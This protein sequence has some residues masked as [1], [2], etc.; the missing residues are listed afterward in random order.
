MK[1]NIKKWLSLCTFLCLFSLV[2][3]MEQVHA[4]P[5]GGYK[6]VN[7]R[8]K[9]TSGENTYYVE[10]ATGNQGYTN[11]YYGADAIYLGMDGN[12]VKFKLSGVIGYVNKSEVEL[13]S[14]DSQVD[15]DKYYTSFYKVKD[16]VIH[17]KI[18]TNIYSINGY[19]TIPIGTNT[20]GLASGKDY[21]SY[22]GHY[23]YSASLEGYKQ[24]TED[25]ISGDYSHAVNAGKPYYN[26]YQY[27]SH[28]TKTNYTAKDIENFIV[29]NLG[30]TKKPSSTTSAGKNESLLYGEQNSFINAQNSFGANALMMFGVAM[31]ESSSGQASIPLRTNN[32]FGHQAYDSA[33]GASANGYATVA[34]GILAHAE[35]FVSIDYMDPKDY[36]NRYQGGHLGNKAS[37]F[38]VKYASDPY[39]GEKAAY[40]YYRFEKP[41]GFQDY[42]TYT[43]GIK[44]SNDVYTI[45]S[46]PDSSSSAIYTTGKV[47]DYSVVILEEVTG[48]SINGN[49][50]WYKIQADP[51][52]NSNRTAF[53]QD[54]GE[55]NY[56]HNYAYIHSSAIDVVVRNGVSTVNK[57]YRVTFNADGGSFSDNSSSKTVTVSSGVI[58]QVENPTKEG[59]EFIGWNETIVPATKD[60]TYTAKWKVKEYH[61][62]FDANGG[63]FQDK[64]TKRDMNVTYNTIPSIDEP[65]R[66]GYHFK[67]WNPTI[68]KA[69]KNTT[70]QAIW[71]KAVF[72]DVT[73]NADGGVFSNGKDEIVVSTAEGSLPKVEEPIKDG[74]VFVGWTPELK[75][76]T[77]KTSYEAIWKKGTVEDYLVEKEGMFYFNY[78]KEQDGK[79]ILQGY[80]TIQG[81][82]N[83]LEKN[84][85]YMIV[86][87]NIDT[88]EEIRTLASRI[89]NVK[90]IPK[91]VY[92]P[93]GHDYT[94]SWFNA[95]LDIDELPLGDYQLYII[96]YTD[97]AYA[98][99]LISNKG[100]KTQDTNYQGKSKVA[101]TGNNYDSR[102]S[103]VELSVRKS[104][105]TKKTGSYIYNQYDKYKTFEFTL[106]N[107]L[108]MVG[109]VYSYGMDLGKNT[110]VR[111][112]II[113]ENKKTYETYTKDLG[114]VVDGGYNVYLPVADNLSKSRAWYNATLDISD[115]PEG[116]YVIYLTT[117]SNIADINKM[118]EKMGRDLSNIKATINHKEYSFS[119]NKNYGN[120]IEMKVEK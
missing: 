6:L 23:F 96:A 28:R 63:M 72:Y 11:G 100:Y 57:T 46:L 76:V 33:P 86:Y 112:K 61:I 71:E 93:D 84:I 55:Y 107:K 65:E 83:S 85:T 88:K 29:H 82:D 105:L 12:R 17:H 7:F 58:P 18:N 4:A 14:M 77:G 39:W 67:G 102:N 52:L 40:Q 2:C 79:F 34:A 48:S 101:I 13:L 32:L 97:Q 89:T 98:K 35:Y 27:L 106:N 8:T 115:I 10:A 50:K 38:N 25:Y 109:N 87:K 54:V 78:L 5:S 117:I 81:F 113:F 74:Y 103:Y 22:D 26:Y 60:K 45:R 24:M 94:Y 53:I 99:S 31:N 16:G 1:L 36:M 80:Q 20:I 95:Q 47:N 44:T 73:F 75:E 66:V 37:G 104:F 30:F 114:S 19:N 119:I 59:Y 21:L 56:D 120:R 116:E 42:G 91:Q 111:R 9:A 15:Y 51:V 90:D 110:N 62:T 43:L 118:T 64:S 70:Y 41:N 3:F 92:S 68:E 49:N 69:S 108:H